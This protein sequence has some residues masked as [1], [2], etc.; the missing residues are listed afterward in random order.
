[1]VEK[2]LI[3]VVSRVCDADHLL[4]FRHRSHPEAG[5]QVPAGT[6]EPGE[7]PSAAA[8]RELLEES[9]L[10]IT[11]FHPL[12]TGPHFDPTRSRWVRRHVLLAR[13]QSTDLAPFSHTVTGGGED[14]NLVFDYFHLPLPTT[15]ATLAGGQGLYLGLLTPNH[16]LLTPNHGLLTTDHGLLTTGTAEPTAG[17]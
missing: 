2:V 12:W 8:A 6:L 17:P 10:R 4:V 9:G 3:Y 13:G 1:M 7:A 16:G 11:C 5:L 15:S 14:Q